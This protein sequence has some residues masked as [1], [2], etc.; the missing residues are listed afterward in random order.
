MLA[1]VFVALAVY[2]VAEDD[3]EYKNADWYDPGS[4]GHGIRHLISTID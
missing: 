4:Q 1:A 2:A 3:Q